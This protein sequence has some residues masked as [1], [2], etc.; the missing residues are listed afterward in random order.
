MAKELANQALDPT[1]LRSAPCGGLPSVRG[2]T[3]GRWAGAAELGPG[4]Y[5]Q[6]V[7][8]TD[9][10]VEDAGFAI[11][12]PQ[13]S[14]INFSRQTIAQYRNLGLATVS[15]RG[16]LVPGTKIH[17]GVIMRWNGALSVAA[18][19]MGIVALTLPPFVYVSMTSEHFVVINEY[20]FDRNTY[21]TER[22]ERSCLGFRFNH[23]VYDGF[24]ASCVG[25]PLGGWQCR[26][27]LPDDGPTWQVPCP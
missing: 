19:A 6:L 7:L 15:G 27:L 5:I 3:L 1:N 4:P 12:L 22:R 14:C 24:R 16:G 13:V 20:H 17:G 21:V 23:D 18:G 10:G 11:L 25:V 9:V 2:S 26:R 8:A